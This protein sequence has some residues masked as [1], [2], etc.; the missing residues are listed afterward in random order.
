MF[1]ERIILFLLITGQIMGTP[2]LVEELEDPR[3]SVDR[4]SER[5][6][7]LVLTFY[8]E[9]LDRMRR[10]PAFLETDFFFLQRFLLWSFHRPGDHTAE[11][12]ELLEVGHPEMKKVMLSCWNTPV[13]ILEQ[14]LAEAYEQD[15]LAL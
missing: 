10:N 14:V 11:A 15:D 8:A 6:E 12:A 5:L 7:T 13:P 3:G 4:R 2:E 1:R 9:L